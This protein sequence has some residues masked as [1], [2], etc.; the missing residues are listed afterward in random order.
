[1]WTII[2]EPETDPFPAGGYDGTWHRWNLVREDERLFTVVKVD[3]HAEMFAGDKMTR[4]SVAAVKTNGRSEVER[5]LGADVPP[6]VIE[7]GTVRDPVVTARETS[8]S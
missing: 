7:V 3:R 5:H 6:R 4:R 1:M 2:G 8:V